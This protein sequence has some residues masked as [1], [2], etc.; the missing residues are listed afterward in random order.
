MGVERK[1]IE[2]L[3]DPATPAR[4]RGKPVEQPPAP[5]SA[6]EPSRRRRSAAMAAP[7][8]DEPGVIPARYVVRPAQSLWSI[9]VERLGD[10]DRYREILNLNPTLRG[11]PARLKPGQEITLPAG[12]R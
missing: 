3:A 4:G 2:G 5:P 6:A 12:V 8:A 1:L 11:D 10:G 7:Q 9:A